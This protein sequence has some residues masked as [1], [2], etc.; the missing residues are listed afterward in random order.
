MVTSAMK[1]AAVVAMQRYLRQQQQ[2]LQLQLQFWTTLHL[3]A[4]GVANAV[5]KTCTA[6]LVRLTIIF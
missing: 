2:Q 5:S 1:G 3:L 4:G 6:S